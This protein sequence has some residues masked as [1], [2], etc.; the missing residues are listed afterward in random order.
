MKVSLLTVTPG[1]SDDIA[2]VVRVFWKDACFTVGVPGGDVEITH[3]ETLSG[4]ILTCLVTMTGG[5]SGER[6]RNVSPDPLIEKR[7][8]KRQ[9]KQAVYDAMRQATRH[10]PPWGS[11]TGIRPTR[12]LY[13]AFARGLDYDSALLEI[14]DTFSVI[15]EKATLLGRI[16]NVQRE[17]PPP[18]HTDIDLYIGIPFCVTR[19]AYCSFICGEVGNGKLLAPYVDTLIGEIRAVKALIAQRGLRPRAFYMGGGTPTSLPPELLARVLDAAGEWIS[20]CAESTVEAGRPDTITAEKLQIIRSAGI[21]RLSVNPQTAHDETLRTIGRAHTARQTV[22]AYTL[23][24]AAG[25][26]H[27]NMDLIA[28]LPGEDLGMFLQTLNFARALY[29]E[30]L[31]IHTLSIKR[32]SLLHLWEATLPDGALAESMVRAGAEAA[33]SMGLRPYYLYRQKNTAGNQENVGY[34][35]PGHECL[36]NVDMMEETASVMA[37]GAGGVSKRL[38]PRQALIKRVYNVSDIAAY[39]ARADE[40]AARKRALW[41]E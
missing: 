37:L 18:E 6:S 2:D 41:D 8:H 20:V 26:G 13:E 11:L 40:M 24:R 15:R 7:L 34:A 5:A 14:Q 1:F 36:Y 4:G 30:S 21:T 28:G 33:G 35:L 22:D 12:L 25:F 38:F 32:A 10:T 27:I 39:M 19:C 9:L 17:L 16:V 23:A 29:P 31:T 3:T